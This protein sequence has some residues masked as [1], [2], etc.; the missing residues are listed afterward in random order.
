AGDR[1]RRHGPLDPTDE[2]AGLADF[3]L[4]DDHCE[5]VAADPARDVGGAH[6]LADAVGDLGEDGVAGEVADPVVDLLEAVDVHDHDRAPRA[7]H[8]SSRPPGRGT[9]ARSPAPPAA[10]AIR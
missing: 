3:D 4:G 8:R 5:L 1:L 9:R 10:P 2:L 7:P 6:D